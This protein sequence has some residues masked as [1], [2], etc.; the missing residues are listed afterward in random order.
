MKDEFI[1]L[2]DNEWDEDEKE[3]ILRIQKHLSSYQFIFTRHIKK[4]V[5]N[6]LELCNKL[7]KKITDL[8]LQKND[9]HTLNLL[10]NTN[11]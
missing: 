1:I 9:N 5:L 8:E 7:K 4:D 6:A 3:L 11:T 10:N 2:L